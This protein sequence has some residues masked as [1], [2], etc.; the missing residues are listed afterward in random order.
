M[1]TKIFI[2]MP[3]KSVTKSIDFFSNLGFR[4]DPLFTDDKAGCIIIGE[5]MYAMLVLES[6]FLT[7]TNKLVCDSAKC[8]ESIIAINVESK[9]DVDDIVKK[10]KEYGGT[11][12]KEA[13]DNGWM[14]SRNFQ[15]L[16]GHLWDV[17][18]MDQKKIPN[19]S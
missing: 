7:F 12:P 11:E 3:V 5:N 14:Y 18:Y 8:T 17:F 2:N 19:R 16:D 1:V 6:S 10:A 4:F 15:D 13:Q 9:K